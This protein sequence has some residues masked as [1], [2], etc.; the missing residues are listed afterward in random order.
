[1]KTQLI[2][3]LFL[4]SLAF[5]SISCGDD[6]EPNKPCSTA[7]ADELQNEISAL[8]AAAQAYGMNPT[9]ATCLAYKNAAQ[10]YVNALEPYGNCSELTGQLRTDWEASL[11][12]A[13][14]SVAAIQC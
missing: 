10:A 13:K 6:N 8:T 4:F 2:S 12:A 1:M 5:V 14:A 3:I 9:P 7:Y 11:N